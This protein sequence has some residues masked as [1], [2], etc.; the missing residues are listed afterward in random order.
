M[1]IVEELNTK[2]FGSIYR[3]FNRREAIYGFGDLQVKN[4][5]D[6]HFN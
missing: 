6:K 1:K 2:E 5:M 3:E 4:M